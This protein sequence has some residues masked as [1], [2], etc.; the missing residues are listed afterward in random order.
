MRKQLFLNSQY[1]VLDFIM[2]MEDEADRY[3]IENKEGYLRVNAH[4]ITGVLYASRDFDDLYL[5]NSTNDGYFPSF[6]EEFK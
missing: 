5:I 4:S 1:K 3:V 2:R 6:V